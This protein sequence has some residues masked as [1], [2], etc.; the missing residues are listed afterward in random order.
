MNLTEQFENR[1]QRKTL[2]DQPQWLSSLKSSSINKSKMDEMVLDFLVKEGYKQA[3]TDFADETGLEVD[4]TVQ[5]NM[6]EKHNIRQLFLTEEIDQVI[7]TINGIDPKVNFNK[8]SNFDDFRFLRKT[9][10]CF[11]ILN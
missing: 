4:L 6:N 5:K 3:A 2:F 7:A 1:L 9:L 8:S 10:S 11:L